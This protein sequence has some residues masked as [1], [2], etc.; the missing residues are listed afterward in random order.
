M[1][2]SSWV[3]VGV[4]YPVVVVFAVLLLAVVQ[5]RSGA[6]TAYDLWRLNYKSTEALSDFLNKEK[7]SLVKEINDNADDVNF[8]NYCLTKL[9]SE[10]TRSV[11]LPLENDAAE[12][13]AAAG[14]NIPPGPSATTAVASTNISCGKLV[15]VVLVR[16][17][18]TCRI[19]ILAIIGQRKKGRP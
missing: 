9:K 17:P 11:S 12:K 3:L 6:D 10:T 15:G 8:A 16:L 1:K 13:V 7:Q 2:K 4:F 14:A 19:A 5:L 18:S